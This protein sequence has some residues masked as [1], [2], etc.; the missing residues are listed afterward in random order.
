L[1]LYLGSA[2]YSLGTTLGS[3]ISS[4]LSSSTLSTG[5]STDS[6]ISRLTDVV[7]TI[8]SELTTILNGGES[9]IY[10]D[11]A[12]DAYDDLATYV[13][14]LEEAIEDIYDAYKEA[15]QAYL[16]G[17]SDIKDKMDDSID[18]YDRI[19][20]KIEHNI[21]LIELLYGDDAYD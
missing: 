10:G 8:D 4:G 12:Q 2:G 20:K 5:S 13:E 19:N 9:S 11:H 7:G 18:D 1:Q 14:K 6:Y 3:A 16:N 15:Y 17:W 21:K